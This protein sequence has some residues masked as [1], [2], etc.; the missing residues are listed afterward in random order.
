[1]TTRIFQSQGCEVHV[2]CE[3]QRLH[4]EIDD[5]IGFEALRGRNR[6][7]ILQA[8]RAERPPEDTE[9]IKGIDVLH[10]DRVNVSLPLAASLSAEE[11]SSHYTPAYALLAKA[12]AFDDRLVVTVERWLHHGVDGRVGRKAL[13]QSVRKLLG[14]S[15]AERTA[16][17][18]LDAAAHLL[19]AKIPETTPE[20]LHARRWLAQFRADPK[21]PPPLG[22]WSS[23]EQLKGIF[24]HDRLLATEIREAQVAEALAAAL[25]RDPALV[26][27]YRTHLR[28]AA[29]LCGPLVRPGILDRTDDHPGALYPLSDSMEARLVRSILG[30]APIPDGFQLVPELIARIRDGR[31]QTEPTRD[32]GWYSYQQHTLAALLVPDSPA[33]TVGPK[34]RHELERLFAA[35]FGLARETHAKQLE[36]PAA[37]GMPIVVRPTVTV[38]PLPELYRRNADAYAFVRRELLE[39]FGEAV[40]YGHLGAPEDASVGQGLDEMEALLRGAWATASAEL[41]LPVPDTAAERAVFRTFQRM[42]S[43]DPDLT[44]NLRMMVPLYYDLGRQKHRVLAVLGLETKRLTVSFVD[45]P[46][47]WAIDSNGAR[48]DR[49]LVFW[50]TVRTFVRPVAMEIDVPALLDRENFRALCDREKTEEAICDALAAG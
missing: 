26:D 17:G 32:D 43:Q 19:G 12:K 13:T 47:A 6:E 27:A 28:L 1:M 40:V 18:L 36:S 49:H 29:R 14:V 24:L 10:L 34:Y 15:P 45:R 38:E 44:A 35:F 50:P 20:K 42:S 21:Q 8:A 46:K 33:L 22:V 9:G 16:G 37:G 25:S 31:L 7:H 4:A 23:T 3:G 48:V 5:R 2:E 11:V 41:G 30:S 39:F